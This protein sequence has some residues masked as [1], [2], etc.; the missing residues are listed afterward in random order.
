[1][2]RLFRDFPSKHAPQGRHPGAIRPGPAASRPRPVAAG[3]HGADPHLAAWR[4]TGMAPWV[5]TVQLLAVTD[6]ARL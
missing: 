3:G 5:T 1:M 6:T 2:F 4:C